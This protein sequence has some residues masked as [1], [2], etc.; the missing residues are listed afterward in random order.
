[1]EFILPELFPFTEE[2]IAVAFRAQGN[3]SEEAAHLAKVFAEDL[4]SH[5]PENG[6]AFYEGGNFLDPIAQL[7]PDAA[8]RVKRFRTRKSVP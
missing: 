4:R 5:A 8:E 1:M 2:E 3:T 6:F 7:S